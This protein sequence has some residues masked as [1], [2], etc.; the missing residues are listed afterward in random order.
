MNTM[1]N[2]V[3][4]TFLKVMGFLGSMLLTIFAVMFALVGIVA[5][6]GSI[7][8]PNIIGVIGCAGFSFCAFTCWSIRKDPLE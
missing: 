3:S 4:K 2:A 7:I 5:L 8:E 1:E 6:I